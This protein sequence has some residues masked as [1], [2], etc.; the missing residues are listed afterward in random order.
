MLLQLDLGVSHI[1]RMYRDEAERQFEAITE[2]RG[3]AAE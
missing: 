3:A 2:S 1:R